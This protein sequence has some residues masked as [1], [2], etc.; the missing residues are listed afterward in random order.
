MGRVL[1]AGGAGGGGRGSSVVRVHGRVR[2]HDPVGHGRRRRRVDADGAF[3]VGRRELLELLVER[4]V[5][6]AVDRREV[7]AV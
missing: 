6:V 4:F 1:V 2:T 5:K 3:R 7:E